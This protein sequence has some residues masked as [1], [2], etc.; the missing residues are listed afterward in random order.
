[1]IQDKRNEDIE[2]DLLS[3]TKLLMLQISHN[4]YLKIT[5][6]KQFKVLCLNQHDAKYPG[7]INLISNLFM[8]IT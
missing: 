5:D 7:N 3:H 8:S 1:M 4:E 2:F 6:I